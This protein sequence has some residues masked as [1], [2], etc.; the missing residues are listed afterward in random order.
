MKS[1]DYNEIG[2]DSLVESKEI[3]CGNYRIFYKFINDKIYIVRV[4]HSKM[5]FN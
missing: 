2:K 3:V 5:D 4:I 1:V